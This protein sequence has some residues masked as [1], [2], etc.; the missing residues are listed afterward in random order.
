MTTTEAARALGLSPTTVRRQLER[1]ALRGSKRGR[2]WWLLP[3][4]VERYRRE[5]LGTRRPP[6]EP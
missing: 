6:A 5:S 1:G 2:D 3:S 4:E